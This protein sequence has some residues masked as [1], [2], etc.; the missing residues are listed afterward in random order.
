MIDSLCTHGTARRRAGDGRQRG[1]APRV[2]TYVAW[3]DVTP[4]AQRARGRH[5]HVS[6]HVVV[7]MRA[8]TEYDAGDGQEREA[9][10]TQ[11]RHGA[12]P[13]R[14]HGIRVRWSESMDLDHNLLISKSRCS[15]LADAVISKPGAKVAETLRAR[16]E[17]WRGRAE[18]RR[19]QRPPQ[20]PR[21][22][23]PSPVAR[24]L[25]VE[26][27]GDERGPPRMDARRCAAAGKRG[28][29]DAREG[30]EARSRRVSRSASR[31]FSRGLCSRCAV[32]ISAEMRGARPGSR[33]CDAQS[34]LTRWRHRRE[35][36]L[37]LENARGLA[38]K[39]ACRGRRG[40]EA[41]R[42]RDYV[43]RSVRDS[44]AR[45]GG[46]KRRASRRGSNRARRAWCLRTTC[47]RSGANA[48]HRETRRRTTSRRR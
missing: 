16:L 12:H 25:S 36:G 4:P 23:R 29:R 9:G 38:S 39:A 43:A 48:C 46:R 20:R 30:D 15:A 2:T 19:C 11:G 44:G 5:P 17:R 40:A 27:G 34:T 45:K 26:A 10:A 13:A 33:R 14:R 31:A 24:A 18:A 1:E 6:C 41:D 7:T 8:K 35:E 22:T 32:S 28:R 21:C 3:R 42:L 37:C 47:R